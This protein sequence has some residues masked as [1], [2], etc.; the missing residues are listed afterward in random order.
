MKRTRAQKLSTARR[1]VVKKFK[2]KRADRGK[3]F[4][5]DAKTGG[6]VLTRKT[7]KKVFAVYVTKKGKKI[8]VNPVDLG[9]AAGARAHRITTFQL[10]RVRRYKRAA[11]ELKDKIKSLPTSAGVGSIVERGG[12]ISHAKLVD[13]LSRGI[14]RGAG[15]LDP[16]RIRNLKIKL[17]VFI[18]H[19]GKTEAQ[20]LEASLTDFGVGYNQRLRARYVRRYVGARVY[21]LIAETLRARGLVT[22]GSAEHVRRLKCNRGKQPKNWKVIRRERL[23]NDETERFTIHSY[24]EKWHG[25]K[26]Y[27]SREFNTGELVKIPRIDYTVE[28]ET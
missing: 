7:T 6:R 5:I 2:V 20:P 1:A 24:K 11:L 13:R 26:L 19:D 9:G 12:S 14:A 18:Q 25:A 8:P 17:S 22:V 10:S 16:R 15:S 21:G 28:R 3:L 27:N 4:F 23:W